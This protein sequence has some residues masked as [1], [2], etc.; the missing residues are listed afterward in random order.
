MS[1]NK[2]EVPLQEERPL[3]T[4]ALFAYNQEKY[5]AEA[6]QGAFAQ[7]YE[8]LEI[9]ISD[10]CS[11]D[12][13]FLIMKQL[14]ESYTGRKR[15]VLNRNSTNI[16]ISSHV[17]KIHEISSGKIVIH[18]AG[19]D[20]SFPNRTSILVSTFF[21]NKKPPSM[22][23]S[24]AVKID[25][26]GVVRGVLTSEEKDLIHE[27]GCGPLQGNL[28]TNGCTVAI[29][30]NLIEKF[31]APKEGIIAEDV[32]LQRRALLLDGVTYT[33]EV[34]VKY[35]IHQD[36]VTAKIHRK[37]EELMRLSLWNKDRLLRL[38][39][40]CLDAKQVGYSFSEKENFLIDVDKKSIELSEKVLAGNIFFS[41]LGLVESFFVEL[42]KYRKKRYFYDRL[43]LYAFR[44]GS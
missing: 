39:Q 11:T 30:R 23:I 42:I 22:V 18:A 38:D 7:T 20:I 14:V 16:G 40:L 31:S 10:D 4:F 21:K 2:K 12:G 33:P 13:T 19:D 32:L 27:V 5:I 28:P 29:S 15:I 6:I 24:N 41:T 35:R 26:D 1:E 37:A 34:L 17:R 3:V 43:K 8:P 9:I 25:E 44:W 36:S